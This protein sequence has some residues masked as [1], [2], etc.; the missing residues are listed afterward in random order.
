MVE[1]V[2]TDFNKEETMFGS[3]YIAWGKFSRSKN[4]IENQI[5]LPTIF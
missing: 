3:G 2:L 4:N 5:N 1:L